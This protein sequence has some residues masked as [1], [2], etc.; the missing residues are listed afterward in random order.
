MDKVPAFSHTYMSEQGY[1]GEKTLH[2]IKKLLV[3]LP[4]SDG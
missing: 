3:S 2:F 1:G 4:T